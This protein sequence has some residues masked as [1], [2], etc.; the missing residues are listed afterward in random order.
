[1]WNQKLVKGVFVDLVVLDETV[2]TECGDDAD[3]SDDDVL[4]EFSHGCLLGFLF[5]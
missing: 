5:L 1:M 3:G 4:D 2:D